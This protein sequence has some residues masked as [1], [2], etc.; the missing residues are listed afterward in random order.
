[1]VVG[2]IEADS[3]RESLP[4]SSWLSLESIETVPYASEE[5]TR[6][7]SAVGKIIG[8]IEALRAELRKGSRSTS[9]TGREVARIAVVSGT[10][11]VWLTIRRALFLSSG[12]DLQLKT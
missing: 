12:S 1:M 4:F 9:P 11:G 7:A 2:T 8:F 3:R 6:S 5:M 10:V